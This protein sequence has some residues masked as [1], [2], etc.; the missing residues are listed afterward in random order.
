[1]VISILASTDV[2]ATVPEFVSQR[3]RWLN[4]SLFASIH[5]TVMF[6]QIWTSGQNIFRKLWLQVETIYNFVQLIFAFTGPANFF[7]SIL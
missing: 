5:A 7:L 6:F 3:R 1:M 2:P 4:G